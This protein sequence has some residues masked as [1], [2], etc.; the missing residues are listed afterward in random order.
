MRI[1]SIDIDPQGK[2]N[3]IHLGPFVAGLNAVY[4][5]RGAGKSTIAKFVRQLLYSRRR[6]RSGS[7]YRETDEYVGTLQWADANGN[8][9][10]VSSSDPIDGSDYRFNGAYHWSSR[11]DNLAADATNSFRNSEQPW[12]RIGGETFDAVY[13]GRLGETLPE[14]LWAAAR[15]LGIAIRFDLED[16]ETHR[17]LKGEE[18]RLQER[19]HHLRVDDRDREWWAAERRRLAARLEELHAHPELAA[20]APAQNYI[21]T[22]SN[23]SAASRPVASQWRSQLTDLS[24]QLSA[25]QRQEVEL[26]K[27]IA[28]AQIGASVSDPLNRKPTY[29]RDAFDFDRATDLRDDAFGTWEGYSDRLDVADPSYTQATRTY[30]DSRNGVETTAAFERHIQQL[31]VQ[32]VKVREQIA[33]LHRNIRTLELN[34]QNDHVQYRVDAT[35]SWEVEDLQKRLAYSD[36]VLQS[37]TLYEQTRTRLIEVQSQIRGNGPYRNGVQS[38]FLQTVERYVRELSAGALR[39]LPTWSM[40][41]LRRD[42]SYVT[43]LSRN[44]KPESYREVYRDYR[45]DASQSDFAVPPS[46]SHERQLVELAIRMAIV[47]ASSH[48]V[49]RLPLLLDDALD[50]FHGQQLE[51]VVRVVMQFASDG[52]QILLLTSE[53]EVARRVRAQQGWVSYLMTQRTAEMRPEFELDRTFDRRLDVAQDAPIFEREYSIPAARGYRSNF[54]DNHLHVEPQSKHYRFL[55]TS[56][57]NSVLASD[58][59]ANYLHQDDFYRPL[60]ETSVQPLVRSTQHFAETHEPMLAGPAKLPSQF[61]LAE[62][63]RIEDAPGVTQDKAARFR[64]L[65]INTVGQLVDTDA[66]WIADSLG[67]PSWSAADI[68]NRQREAMLMCCVP[69]LRAFDARVLV[70]CG[71]DNPTMLAEMRPEQ[72]LQRVESFLATDR[73]QQILRSGTSYELSRIT[74]WIISARRS[75]QHKPSSNSSEDEIRSERSQRSSTAPNRWSSSRSSEARRP[76]SSD[77]DRSGVR[78]ERVRGE[79]VRGERVRGEGVRGERVRSERVRGEVR[80]ESR[81]PQ[82]SVLRTTTT[83]SKRTPNAATKLQS[84]RESSAS[85]PNPQSHVTTTSHVLKFYLSL[86]SPIVDAPS[87]GPKMASRLEPFGLYTVADLIECNA[88]S[89]AQRLNDKR[90]DAATIADWQHQALLVCT[91]PNLRGHDAQILVY[92]DIKTADAL[93]AQ[94]ID[95]LLAAATRFCSSKSGQRLLRGASAP[96]R[97][98]ISDWIAWSNHARSIKAA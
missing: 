98:E 4:G 59:D 28:D 18:R 41:A 54:S 89:I 51:H 97:A 88:T 68:R 40:E 6:D 78:G 46:T 35:L 3:R 80:A 43:G 37:W 31:Q 32:R 39:G 66:S 62:T 24:S 73:G 27:R 70:G 14:R 9:R 86:Q 29:N 13:C 36:E 17:R 16:D 65:G 57:L 79:R 30:Q 47:E 75:L 45:P 74:T 96:D 53:E 5:Q 72:L 38:S 90:F 67:V 2:L 85:K 48:R 49:G 7:E 84:I 34:L 71:L 10:V 77:S 55:P 93:A 94:D 69:Q 23:N 83:T 50:G 12:H 1:V 81:A 60:H 63:S 58:A 82:P 56:D 22:N 76:R 42:H 95:V 21:A 8:S 20:N 92:C 33:S 26:A 87:I 52:Q 25:L 11:H 91:V 15:E 19:L 61:F 44:G 64:K